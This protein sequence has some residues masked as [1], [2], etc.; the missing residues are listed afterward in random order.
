MVV[1]TICK[2]DLTDDRIAQEKNSLEE[3]FLGSTVTVDTLLLE[4]QPVQKMS[5][6]GPQL[7]VV[8]G[9]GYIHETILD[10]L[11]FRISS[12]SF[13]QCNTPAAEVL[14]RTVREM[15]LQGIDVEKDVVVLD[16]C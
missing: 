7:S 5:S 16:V 11:K 2:Q 4:I 12:S 3:Y 9:T 14:Y 15:A 8:T 13:F 10:D 1:I 6:N